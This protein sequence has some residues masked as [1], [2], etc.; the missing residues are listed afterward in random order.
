VPKI[1]IS[2]SIFEALRKVLMSTEWGRFLNELV[3]ARFR[4]I[5]LESIMED[6]ELWEVV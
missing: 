3:S 2:R 4:E 1:G 6:L 5:T